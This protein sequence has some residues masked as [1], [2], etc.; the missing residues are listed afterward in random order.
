MLVCWCYHKH[1]LPL[2]DMYFSWRINVHDIPVF[3][4]K[5]NWGSAFIQVDV[6]R[7]SWSL[8][9]PYVTLLPTATLMSPADSKQGIGRQ[10]VRMFK[11]GIKHANPSPL[12]LTQPSAIPHLVVAFVILCSQD[13]FF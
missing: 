7:S 9:H 3:L 1:H 13:R 5:G 11:K 2:S 12:L 6:G 10:N 8:D 4:C